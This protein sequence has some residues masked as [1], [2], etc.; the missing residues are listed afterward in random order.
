VITPHK[1]TYRYYPESMSDSAIW[2]Q[3]SRITSEMRIC[4]ADCLPWIFVPEPAHM[5]RIDQWL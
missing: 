2:H 4:W 3:S 5:Q 1:P